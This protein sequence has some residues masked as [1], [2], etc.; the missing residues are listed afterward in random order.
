MQPPDPI[1]TP[2][3]WPIVSMMSATPSHPPLQGDSDQR[4]YGKDLEESHEWSFLLSPSHSNTPG[5]VPVSAQI[6]VHVW[7][8]WGVHVPVC[9]CQQLYVYANMCLCV[10]VW[11]W[12]LYGLDV[13]MRVEPHRQNIVCELMKDRERSHC[14][15]G[16]NLETEASGRWQNAED[17]M[18]GVFQGADSHV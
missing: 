15:C 18:P 12:C 10:C 6:C 7:V 8:C 14:E 2:L 5:R 4:P 16:H 3:A 17:V 9:E 1:P 13:N 11:Y